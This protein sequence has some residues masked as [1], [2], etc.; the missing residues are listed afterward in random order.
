M[1]NFMENN[2]AFSVF[3]VVKLNNYFISLTNSDL[4]DL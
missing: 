1:I 2:S 3:S 4:S